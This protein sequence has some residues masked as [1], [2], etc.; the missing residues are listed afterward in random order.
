MRLSFLLWQVRATGAGP[1]SGAIPR[2][3]RRTFGQA[4]ND[5]TLWYQI[6]RKINLAGDTTL[7]G[8]CLRNESMSDSGLRIRSDEGFDPLAVDQEPE[9]K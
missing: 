4:R 7:A 9:R 1:A 8:R 2:S 5:L 6:D 3:C